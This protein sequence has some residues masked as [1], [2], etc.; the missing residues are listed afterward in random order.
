MISTTLMICIGVASVAIVIALMRW[1]RRRV[2][3]TTEAELA[4]VRDA[5]F[6]SMLLS[7]AVSIGPARAQ[8]EQSGGGNVDSG[9]S[10]HG[11]HLNHSH[12]GGGHFDGGSYSDGGTGYGGG[13]DAGGGGGI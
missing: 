11:S 9:H 7:F 8:A 2:S 4:N 6:A 3:A 12:H 1:R 13:G 5:T 10:W